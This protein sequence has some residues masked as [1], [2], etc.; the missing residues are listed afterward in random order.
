MKIYL[1]ALEDAGKSGTAIGCGDS[2]VAVDVDSA[3][4]R[5]ALE[6]LLQEKNHLYGQSGLYNSL[7]QSD[8]RWTNLKRARDPSRLT[9][10]VRSN[11]EGY[12]TIHG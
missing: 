4:A 2:L 9:L 10:A 8:L 6:F 5:S 11:W 7:Y 3:D 1:V 12:A